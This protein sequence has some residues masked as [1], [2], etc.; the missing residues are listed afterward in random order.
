MFI[1]IFLLKKFSIEK[2]FCKNKSLLNCIHEN[3]Q[4]FSNHLRLI[5]Y[6]FFASVQK[7]ECKIKFSTSL[8]YLTDIYMDIN[9]FLRTNFKSNKICERLGLVVNR[10]AGIG[11]IICKKLECKIQMTNFAKIN[12]KSVHSNLNVKVKCYIF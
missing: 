12:L 11:K 9:Q 10:G 1:L 4:L 7:V 3:F 2:C 8:W 5:F 6:Y